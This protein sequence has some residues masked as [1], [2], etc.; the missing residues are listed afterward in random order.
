MQFNS[1]P[2]GRVKCLHE[3]EPK[4][5]IFGSEESFA[6]HQFPPS[7]GYSSKWYC[8]SEAVPHIYWSTEHPLESQLIDSPRISWNLDLLLARFSY[9][10]ATENRCRPAEDLSDT[11]QLNDPIMITWGFDLLH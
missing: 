6:K 7:F 5:P 11:H 3:I 4:R 2:K 8:I 10:A 1:R 9:A